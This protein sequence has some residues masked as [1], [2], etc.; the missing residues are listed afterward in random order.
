MS[1]PSISE[2]NQR[3]LLDEP[4]SVS[5]ATAAL[6]LFSFPQPLSLLL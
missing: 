2:S 4:I 1:L 6:S 5:I 3:K